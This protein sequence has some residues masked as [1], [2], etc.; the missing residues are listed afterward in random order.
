[1]LAERRPGRRWGWKWKRER[2]EK[3]RAWWLTLL[4]VHLHWDL[5]RNIGKQDRPGRAVPVV[6]ELGLTNLSPA[7]CQESPPLGLKSCPPYVRSPPPSSCPPFPLH[8]AS[9]A[10]TTRLLTCLRLFPS[11]PWGKS[12]HIIHLLGG[13]RSPKVGSFFLGS[14]SAP[15]ALSGPGCLQ[16]SPP[17]KFPLFFSKLLLF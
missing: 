1:M 8:M 2:A 4:A 17:H 7:G 6:A 15:P 13:D 3:G 16:V 5:I 11:D 12:S 14:S 9:N 10:H